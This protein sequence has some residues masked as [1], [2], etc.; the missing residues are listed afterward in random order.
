MLNIKNS[1]TNS[2][3]KEK[4]EKLIL[5][6][7]SSF[8]DTPHIGSN[9]FIEFISS[10]HEE[11]GTHAVKFV[12]SNFRLY[13]LFYINLFITWFLPQNCVCA[14]KMEDKRGKIYK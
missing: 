5:E 12:I 3:G 8:I 13:I 11:K 4:F 2:Q 7:T 10:Y 6:P 1:A 14:R 9:R